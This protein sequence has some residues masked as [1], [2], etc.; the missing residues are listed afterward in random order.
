MTKQPRRKRCPVCGDRFL[1]RFNTGRPPRFCSNACKRASNLEITRSNRHIL[2]L[3]TL[4]D[5]LSGNLDDPVPFS[6]G[7][8]VRDV[9][10]HTCDLI[11]VYRRRQLEILD[12]DEVKR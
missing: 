2:R 8:S 3:E 1:P 7:R 11:D 6:D 4:R 10:K 9:Y 5:E 12:N